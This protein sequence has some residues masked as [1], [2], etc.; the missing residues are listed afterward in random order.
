MAVIDQVRNEINASINTLARRFGSTADPAEKAVIGKAIGDLN[1][2]LTLL[3]QAALLQAASSLAGATEI[4]ERAVAAARL[5]PFDGYLAALEAHLTRFNVLSGRAHAGDSLESAPLSPTSGG[6]KKGRKS[7]KK[8]AKKKSTRGPR[9]AAGLESA[10][11]ESAQPPL[12]T[13]TAFAD[14]RSEYQALYDRC[15]VRPGCE[16]NVA[17]YVK[18]LK[19][20]QPNYLLIEQQ[21]NVPWLFVGII[22]G[23]ECGFNFAGHLHNGDPLTA[24]TVQ[25]P[26]GRPIAG[27]PPFTWH[28]SALDALRLKKLDRVTDWSIPHMLYLLEGYNGFGYRRRGLPSPYLWSFSNNYEKGKFVADGRYDPEA[29][30]KQCG[31]ALML[32]LMR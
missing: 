15:T 28:D 17:Y 13:S 18:R 1:D 27:S 8:K 19:Q 30:S 4:L 32:R 11:L 12:L 20:G 14:L 9:R 2:E 5:G 24:R 23:M 6:G 22:H 16:G 29:V 3:N 31:A 26:K 21:I 7:K 25:V 10:L